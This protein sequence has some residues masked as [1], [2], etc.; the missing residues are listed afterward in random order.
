MH[1]VK[2]FDQFSFFIVVPQCQLITACI[3]I[4]P[5]SSYQCKGQFQAENGEV[6]GPTPSVIFLTDHNC[7]QLVL[8]CL[9]HYSITRFKKKKNKRQSY[10][11]Q[12]I[13][14]GKIFVTTLLN[15]DIFRRHLEGVKLYIHA[16]IYII[17]QL[18]YLCL[19]LKCY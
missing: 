4:K 11:I 19:G 8:Y 13:N 15:I 9:P 6:Q 7:I 2:S 1:N 5:S 10:K 17:L 16:C 14:I 18:M 3:Q 12:M